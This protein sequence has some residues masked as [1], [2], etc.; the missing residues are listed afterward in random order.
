MTPPLQRWPELT[1]DDETWLARMAD[2]LPWPLL[3]LAPDG[4]VLHAN[5]AAERLL[6]LGRPLRRDLQ[7]RIA[8]SQAVQQ[9]A[10]QDALDKACAGQ[11]VTLRWPGVPRALNGTLQ[12][13]PGHAGRDALLLALSPPGGAG[14]DAS[15]YAQSFQLTPAEER[16]LSLLAAGADT[17]AAAAALGVSSSTVR[18]HLR[19]LRSKTGHPTTAALLLDMGRLPPTLLDPM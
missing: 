4:W 15:A 19:A 10:W 9:A 2:A 18:T 12:R 6:D 16:V 3:A 5:Q 7:G 1:A 8:A 14:L 17:A 11:R 13:L